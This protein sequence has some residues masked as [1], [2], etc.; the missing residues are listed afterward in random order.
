[1]HVVRTWCLDVGKEGSV[2]CSIFIFF[3][4]S[5]L[6]CQANELYWYEIFNRTLEF[7]LQLLLPFL[8]FSYSATT[9]KPCSSKISKATTFREFQN[10]PQIMLLQIRQFF[11]SVLF[12]SF[13]MPYVRLSML[14]HMTFRSI[15]FARQNSQAETRRK[16]P[17]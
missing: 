4:R 8:I 16:Q 9:Y 14:R 1:M 13:S 6:T 7:S 15:L 10:I 12:A 5:N 17:N 3:K 11:P 2:C